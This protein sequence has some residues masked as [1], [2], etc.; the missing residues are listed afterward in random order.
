MG[1]R[2]LIRIPHSCISSPATHRP[3][4]THWQPRIFQKQQPTHVSMLLRM[5]QAPMIWRTPRPHPQH[6]LPSSAPST[7]PLHLLEHSLLVKS[8]HHPP[9]PPRS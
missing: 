6:T 2:A 1:A 8:T 5:L 4:S 9:D 3:S 7:Q